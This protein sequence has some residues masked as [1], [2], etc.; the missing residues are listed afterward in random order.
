MLLHATILFI[1]L[2]KEIIFRMLALA[3]SFGFSPL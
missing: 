2:R 3:L 1:L